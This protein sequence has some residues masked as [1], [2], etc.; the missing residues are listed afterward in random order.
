MHPLNLAGISTRRWF[1]AIF[2][3]VFVA[4]SVLDARAD[5]PSPIDAPSTGTQPDGLPFV[6]RPG[7][8]LVNSAL[9]VLK[10]PAQDPV[11]RLLVTTALG[12][13]RTAAPV[14]ASP[15]PLVSPVIGVLRG[16][17]IF[18][19]IPDVLAVGQ[20]GQSLRINGSGLATV[21]SL[22]LDPSIDATIAGFVVDDSGDHIDAIVD[23][24]SGAAPGLRR[25]RAFDALGKAIADAKPGA[26]QVLL[27]A[28]LPR[29]ESVSPNLVARDG[30]YS[31]E[32]RGFNLRG[33]PL[34]NR[35]QFDEQPIVAIAP[36]TGIT[37][38]GEP[39]SNDAGT[40][41]TVPIAVDADAPLTDRLIQVVTSSG[42]SSTT[43]S[44]A[45]TLHLSD[46]A[47]HRLSPFVSPQLG[48]TRTNLPA[49]STHF[50]ASGILGVSRGPT[51][52]SLSPN[53]A[54]PGE[55]VRL[56]LAGQG[57][58]EMTAIEIDPAQGIEIDATTLSVSAVEVSVDIHIANDAALL[59][60]GVSLVAPTL[61]VR[62][63]E[64]FVLR[65]APPQLQALTPTWLLRDGSSQTIELQGDH[66]GQV[67]AVS[68][69]PDTN[70]VIE[71]LLVV[72]DSR[73]L[74]TLRTSG[75]AELGPRVIKLM[76]PSG[77]SSGAPSPSNVLYIVDRS[78]VLTPFVSPVLGVLRQ[79]PDAVVPDVFLSAPALGVVR[80]R[81]ATAV[82]PTSLARGTTTHVTI[83]GS[84]LE[85]VDSVA[86]SP[87]DG[88]ALGGISIAD[89]GLSLAFDV[90]VAVDAPVGVR[91]TELAAGSESI[92]FFPADSAL[93]EIS[94]NVAVGPIAEPDTYAAITNLPL[95]VDASNGVLVNDH[96]P[97]GGGP[98]YAVLRRLTGHGTIALSA[99]GGF[100]YSPDENF[101]GTDRFEYSAGSGALVGASTVVTLTVAQVNDAVDDNYTTNDNQVLNVPAALGL[102][103]ND[104]VAVGESITIE[105]TSQPTL[106]QI[107]VDAD[108]G[109]VY[110]PSGAS[111]EDHFGYRLVSAGVPS[112]PAIVTITVN[113]L[114][115]APIAVD[116]HYVVDSGHVLTVSAPGVLGN[117]ADPDG[118]ALTP[119]IISS[120]LIGAVTLN[121]NGSFTY[122]PP[123]D[124]SGQTDFVY[125]VTD[126]RGLRA[127]ATV[128]INVNDHLAPLP[129]AYSLDE[130]EVLFV[131]APGV[132][133]NDSIIPQGALR[134]VVVQAPTLGTVQM[135]NDGSF[136]YR[137]TSPDSSGADL[138]RYRLEDASIASY[139][140]DVNLTIRA[141]N[142]PPQS[143]DDSFLTDE[144]VELEVAAPGVLGNDTDIDSTQL[145]ARLLEPPAH[146]A[147]VVRADGS[148]SYVPEVN[149]R[150]DD[151]FTY[152]TV[153]DAGAASPG[154]VS[155][156]VTQP[157]TATNDVYLVDVD[158]PLEITDP[159]EGLLVN[160]H[161]APEDD[162]LSVIPG[163]PPAHGTL[164][165]NEDGTF[166]YEPDPGYVGID[167]F[168]YQVTDGL[169]SSN[170]GNVTLA[171]GITSLPRANPD[172]YDMFE[173]EQL[174]V[175]AEHGVLANDTD[176]D[177][178]HEDLRA[179][180][181]SYD[182]RNL[183]V[184]LASDGSFTSRTGANFY[185]ETFF[186][187]Q[188]YDG[189][190]VSNAVKVTLTVN[191]VNDG[192]EANDDL[193]GVLRNTVF[194]SNSHSITINDHY[195]SDYPVNF[196]IAQSAQFGTVELDQQSG[197]FRY[198]PQQNFS[199]VDTFVYHVYQTGTGIGD[200]ATVTLRTNGPP[201]T[202]PDVYTVTEDSVEVVTPG[203]IAND[204]D[205]DGDPIR[206]S[207]AE[208]HG[209]HYYVVLGLSDLLP[210]ATTT[211]TSQ[212]H[213]Y[214]SQTLR[215]MIGDGT[216]RTY[217]DVTVAVL[218]VPDAPVVSADNYITPRNTELVVSTSAK[219]VLYNDFDP[220]TRPYP[221]GPVW[222][223]ATG[224]DL[225]PISAQLVAL[226]THGNLVFSPIGTFTYT[227]NTDYSGIDEF[228]YHA[229]DATGRQSEPATVRIRV[230]TPPEATSDAYVLNEDVVL[231]V[232]ASEG[233]LGNDVDIDGDSLSASFASSGCAPCNGHVE[234]HADGGFRYTP[235]ANYY[236][237]DEFF[238]TVRDG[239][240]GTDVGRVSLTI[241]PVNDPPYTEPDTYRTRE[242]EVLVAPEPQGILRNDR[243]VD[244]ELLINAEL[245]DPPQRGEV[246][247]MPDGSFTY[248]PAVNVN[249]RDTFSY[250]VYC[251]QMIRSRFSLRRSTIRR[252]S[253][254]T[255]TRRPRMRSSML[256]PSKACLPM[257]LMSMVRSRPR[258]LSDCHNTVRWICGPTE[259][260]SMRRM[261]SSRASISFSTRWT[262]ASARLQRRSPTSWC[263]P[264][265]RTWSSSSRMTC[266]DLKG[267]A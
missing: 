58:G 204:S 52:Q 61:K 254:T 220:D 69:S 108:G 132:L 247:V 149:F 105:L 213:F 93:I 87:A 23:V 182:Q 211:I 77:D 90:D 68:V 92:S 17:T 231:S 244:G 13:E 202:A 257:M 140:V 114:N 67:T 175:D 178:P 172:A 260:S 243:E 166:R 266:T 223:A 8:V 198:T 180:L 237:P 19:L 212:Y 156:A 188:V 11:A 265:I 250:R 189:T 24:A 193:Y 150:G 126:P 117:D 245:I 133:T 16:A 124:F 106:G 210:T 176:A 76:S 91:R 56:T 201:V 47:L 142:D 165:L 235:N 40:L 34:L 229:L 54:S 119:R 95:S 115:E 234:V 96:D 81:S 109:F 218:P 168:T 233:L 33:L 222:A 62:A 255:I 14:E 145:S 36:S 184:T 18:E 20:N 130:G 5:S 60:R 191:P 251:P 151:T 158:T 192:V 139:T 134:V 185:G 169:S 153:D 59:A 110:Q 171:V 203:P 238:Y 141:V 259:V 242:D 82:T 174:V 125:E 264:S 207:F 113:D 246:V 50:L 200:T 70:L 214:G 104:V 79:A 75:T 112:A 99:D 253:P 239:I 226:P 43:L 157:P 30:T 1:G 194:D 138:F 261:A 65:D 228:T 15:T 173:D 85:A 84:R 32:I 258:F 136:V 7:D 216:E 72:S 118:D 209:D 161:D 26:S 28:D 53:F 147:V 232:P 143:V 88:I 162:E 177:T 42:V 135:A 217:G 57:L 49:P 179:F 230:N 48:V 27:A 170:F 41:V 252:L 102:L 97:N 73:A 146:G 208:F 144:N 123:A 74:L 160:D 121:A 262:T 120:P 236:G 263:G 183:S 29:I 94:D 129:D 221:N 154:S 64:L 45:N 206:Y 101:I 187:Y 21:D 98:L 225:L 107:A 51:I 9:G 215:Y 122:T 55:T 196:E 137:T 10:T 83:T 71:D 86:L 248:T 46:L 155:I 39:Q 2:A 6:L 190:S 63:P 167:T 159:L 241:L 4:S 100:I 89:D 219:S 164:D 256:Q 35:P 240:A 197:H 163:A 152:E 195:D 103:S 199:G 25:L 78:L 148:F 37:V 127:H 38:G 131:D 249:G 116:D 12:V 44:P 181:V 186:I 128:F 111:G 205:P 224:L 31:L 80:G 3:C 22:V 66:L 227:P 267:R